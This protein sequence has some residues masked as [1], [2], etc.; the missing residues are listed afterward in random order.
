MSGSVDGSPTPGHYCW[1]SRFRYW[2]VFVF[3]FDGFSFNFLLC[4]FI[5]YFL[6]III[7]C[8]CLIGIIFILVVVGFSFCTADFAVVFVIFFEFVFVAFVLHYP[9]VI[10]IHS[11][12][13]RGVV[14]N[15][16]QSGLNLKTF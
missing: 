11:C 3:F 2:F 8:D 10:I 9:T 4:L 14:E 15:K 6:F 16:S 1:S 5:F 7:D 13:S 12:N